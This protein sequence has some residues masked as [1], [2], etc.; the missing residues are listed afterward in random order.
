MT[1][2]PTSVSAPSFASAASSKRVRR[3]SW[4]ALLVV[5]QPK[6]YD[7][8]GRWTAL[9]HQFAEHEKIDVRALKDRASPRPYKSLWQLW[10]AWAA[11]AL[12]APTAETEAGLSSGREP[13]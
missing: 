5:A 9:V 10:A 12:P 8:D 6:A 3:T 13:L 7:P 2:L 11:W 1:K 4:Q